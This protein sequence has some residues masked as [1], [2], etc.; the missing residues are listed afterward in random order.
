MDQVI[1]VLHIRL[2]EITPRKQSTLL[3]ALTPWLSSH[4]HTYILEMGV[5]F[6]VYI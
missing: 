5:K 6:V 4:F 1:Q 3:L 2:G